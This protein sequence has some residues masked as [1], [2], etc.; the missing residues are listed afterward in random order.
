MTQ[1]ILFS[2]VTFGPMV[3]WKT[4]GWSSSGGI[5]MAVLNQV[6]VSVYFEQW[7]LSSIDLFKV[8]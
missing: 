2:V 4:C 1:H 5:L 3:G 8:D 7:R 6:N